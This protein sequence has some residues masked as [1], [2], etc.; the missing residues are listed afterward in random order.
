MEELADA[1]DLGTAS[2]AVR[3]NPH[4]VAIDVAG[5]LGGDNV[6][7]LCAVVLAYLDVAPEVRLTTRGVTAVEEPAGE[8]LLDLSMERRAGTLWIYSDADGPYDRAVEE[9]RRARRGPGCHG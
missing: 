4:G 5:A 9:A 7:G 8:A 2:A 1:I 3:V 6:A